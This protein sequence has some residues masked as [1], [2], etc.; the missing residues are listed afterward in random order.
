MDWPEGL[1]YFPNFISTAEEKELILQLQAL[2]WQEVILFGQVARRRVCHFGLLYNY[3]GRT[4]QVTEQAPR[5]LDALIA[6]S[7]QLIQAPPEAIAEILVTEYPI[8]AGINWHRD[9]PVFKDII[10]ISLA[11][12][13]FIYFR[14][15][16]NKKEQIKLFL[17]PG[18]AYILKK[19]I[20]T[21]W[22]HRIPPVKLP[23]YSITLRTLAL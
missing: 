2:C 22:E 8:D 19:A 11:S 18:S 6:R 10:G 7:A 13:S 15:R 21:N 12:S 1:E 17:E 3:E 5:F 14:N 4:V 16:S 20:R 23:R 9:A